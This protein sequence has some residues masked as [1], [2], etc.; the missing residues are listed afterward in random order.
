MSEFIC[1][2]VSTPRNKIKRTRNQLF[3][4]AFMSWIKAPYLLKHGVVHLISLMATRQS[5]SRMMVVKPWLTTRART[6]WIALIFASS[7]EEELGTILLVEKIIALEESCATAPR[8]VVCS[9]LWTP[10]ST[11]N[12]ITPP[13]GGDHKSTIGTRTAVEIW[14]TY[15][16]LD[17]SWCTSDTITRAKLHHCSWRKL[18]RFFQSFQ[19]RIMPFFKWPVTCQ[20]KKA[21][22]HAWKRKVVTGE[23]HL[24]K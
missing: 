18:F 21:K 20:K 2:I 3:N 9:W 15:Y 17:N 16:H 23:K 6:K 1:S 24:A 19:Q 13:G 5:D 12:F 10:T 8:Q 22:N 7:V 14:C 4:Q 11:F